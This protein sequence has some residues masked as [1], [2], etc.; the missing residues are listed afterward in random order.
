MLRHSLTRKGTDREGSGSHFS[1]EGVRLAR[2]VGETLPPISYAA[3]G[4]QPRHLETAMALGVAVDEQVSWPSGY[5]V[6]EVTHHDQWSWDQPF[7]RYAELVAAGSG[8]AQVAR[9]HLGHWHRVIGTLAEGEAALVVSSDGSIE[10]VLVA[11]LPAAH[12]AWGGAM[13]QLE[14]A[15][16]S[17]DGAAVDGIRMLRSDCHKGLPQARA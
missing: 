14:G 2:L 10:P 15:I 5:V 3:V 8:L 13:R 7:V 1:A 16:L 12:S 11:A 9:E 17:W 6:G 4:D